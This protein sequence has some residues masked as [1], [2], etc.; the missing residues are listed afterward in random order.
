M[1]DYE[2][3]DPAVESDVGVYL[4]GTLYLPGIECKYCD[5]NADFVMVREGE[6][7]KDVFPSC[8]DHA[9]MLKERRDIDAKKRLEK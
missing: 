7:Y 2:D 9:E 1:G 6:N 4:D 5:E 8:D 3:E